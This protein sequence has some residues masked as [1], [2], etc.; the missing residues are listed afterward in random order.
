MSSSASQADDDGVRAELVRVRA[1]QQELE[2]KLRSQ[3]REDTA[4]ASLEE[5]RLVLERSV[6]V[7]EARRKKQLA[8]LAR[9]RKHSSRRAHFVAFMSG[10]WFTGAVI[11]LPYGG[12]G[13]AVS[14][15]CLVLGGLAAFILRKV[16][17]R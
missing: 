9:R 8:T 5:R 17:T 1:T 2:E 14:F 7:L 16:Q 6:T 13:V 15:G 11:S 3:L 12:A 4:Y 10:F